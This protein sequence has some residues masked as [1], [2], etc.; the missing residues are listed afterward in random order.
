MMFTLIKPED[1]I[2]NFKKPKL[3]FFFLS[4]VLVTE[5]QDC[6]LQNG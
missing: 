5:E 2:F 3:G 6:K 4:T 1:S